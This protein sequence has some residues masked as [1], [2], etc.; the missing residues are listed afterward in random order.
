MGHDLLVWKG[1]FS[2]K[3]TG[4]IATNVRIMADD[5]PDIKFRM[6]SSAG[7][8]SKLYELLQAQSSNNIDSGNGDIRIYSAIRDWPN[9]PDRK[10]I[11]SLP[12]RERIFWNK[13]EAYPRGF[14]I[15]FE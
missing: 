3:A 4:Q 9:P 2:P 1:E 11:T 12:T 15:S 6:T 8:K 10:L 7:K 14:M 5:L 13:L